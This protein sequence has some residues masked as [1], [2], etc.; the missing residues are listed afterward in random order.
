[1]PVKPVIIGN[2]T[3]YCGDCMDVLRTLDR[4]DVL[5]TDPPYGVG[6]GH[7]AVL[8]DRGRPGY[9]I[10][11]GYA[12]YDDTIDNYAKVVAPAVRLS[13]SLTL[14][15]RGVVFA[16]M[17]AAWLLPA[18]IAM[19]GIYLPAGCGRT[20]WGF[21]TLSH[22]LLY[23]RAPDLH[24]GAKPI[25]VQLTG[26]AE[27]GHPCAKPLNWMRWA[28]DLASR[29]GETILDPFMG[30]GTTGIACARL[31]RKFIGIEIEPSY[32]ALACQ[33]IQ[34]AYRQSDLFIASP[35]SKAQQCLLF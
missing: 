26:S 35:P 7:H 30:S 27:P 32:F 9:L 24:L 16:A 34:D 23:G 3:L 8:A 15:G 10:K 29:D 4:V 22:A 28:V 20:V 25:A 12:T 21:K 5:V 33:R 31:G 6:L 1:M 19:G 14:D 13:L 11:E 17:P 18:P 2:A